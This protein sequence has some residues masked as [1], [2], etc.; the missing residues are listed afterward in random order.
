MLLYFLLFMLVIIIGLSKIPNKNYIIFAILFLFSALRFDVGYDYGAYYK[1]ITDLNSINYERFGIFDRLIID[2]SRELNFYQ[3][4]FIFT[5]FIIIYLISKTVN[6]YSDN[7][8]FSMLIFLAIPIFYLMSLTIIRQYI[9]ISI[10]FFSLKY[11]VDRN[12]FKYFILITIASIFHTT[13]LVTLPMYF[14]YRVKFTKIFSL[15]IIFLS[16]F[17]SPFLSK[18]L[19]LYFPYYSNYFN[20]ASHGK[21]LLY[22]LFFILIF[23]FMHY[24]YIKDYRTSFYFNVYTIG[25]SLYIMFIQLG[26]VGIRI[27][28]YYLIFLIFLIPSILKIYKDK[29]AY[30]IMITLTLFIYIFNFYLF[31]K[32]NYKNAYIPYNIFLNVDEETYNWR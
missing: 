14:L 22:F 18:I 17:I 12:F 9:A 24:K 26:D 23:I 29:Q 21:S 15:I 27:S 13:A 6:N 4:Y 10:V 7:Y 32:N 5:S 31:E 2:L 11:I 8:L 30:F 25:I 16:I 19:I 28:Y 3:F 20:N 1:V